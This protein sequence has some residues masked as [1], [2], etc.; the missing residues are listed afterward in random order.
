MTAS[1]LV[2][3]R[4][5]KLV[6]QYESPDFI[7]TDPISIPHEYHLLADIEISGLFAAIFSWGNRKTI[8]NKSRELMIMMDHAPY[9]FMM[10]HT[11]HDLKKLQSFKH[12]TFQYDDLLY[13]IRFLR[14]HYRHYETLETAFLT[15]GRFESV[16][17]A[18]SQFYSYFF[19]L[20]DFMPRTKKH[21]SHPSTGSTCKRLCMYLRWMVRSPKKGVDFGLWTH[22][23]PR[24]LMI[25]LDVH[26]HRVARNL[27]L[28]QT[29]SKNWHTVNELTEILRTL[30]PN[31]PV[32]YDFALFNLGIKND[33]L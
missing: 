30:D 17:Q 26:V 13:F 24:D 6:L 22:I 28:L 7:Q 11:A 5:E 3:D 21:V 2:Q 8:I 32:K 4:L 25:P 12:R 29:E 23:K 16:E 10:G 14:H 19:S 20:K 9:Q 27:H 15:Q 33:P 18:L 1:G 31:D